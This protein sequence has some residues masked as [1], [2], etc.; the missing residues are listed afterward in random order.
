MLVCVFDLSRER[1]VWDLEKGAVLCSL[2]D[3]LKGKYMPAEEVVGVGTRGRVKPDSRWLII[4][5]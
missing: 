4:P 2:S 5:G 3:L 1:T